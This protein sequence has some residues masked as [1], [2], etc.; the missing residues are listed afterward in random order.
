MNLIRIIVLA[1]NVLQEVLRDRILYITAFY[2]ILLAIAYRAIQEFAATSL[3]KIFL[4]FGLSAMNILGLIIVI[5]LGT[6]LVNK[7]IEKRTI[8]VLIAKPISRSEFIISKYLG[9]C[10]VLAVLLAIMTAIYIGFLQFGSISYPLQ[11][12]LL[13]VLFMFLQLSLINAVSVALGVFTNS[14]VAAVLAFAIY[15]MGNISQDIVKLGS[16][17]KNLRVEQ[18]TQGLY[19]ILPDL[20]RL[21]LKNTAVYGL[22]ALPDTVTLISNLGYGMLYSCVMLSIATLIFLQREF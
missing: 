19:L 21:D 10:S 17:S 7:E 14:L 15:L 2:A 18:I 11:S 1:Q 6:G 4:D 12:L 5:F 22:P 9:L 8:F 16:L 13:A 3:D 20:S